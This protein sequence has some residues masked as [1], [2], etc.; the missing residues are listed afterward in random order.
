MATR[1]KKNIATAAI[2]KLASVEEYKQDNW[3]SCGSSVM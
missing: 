1:M 2:N 3:C